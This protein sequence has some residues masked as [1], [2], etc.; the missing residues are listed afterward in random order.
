MAKGC[1]RPARLPW[2]FDDPPQSRIGMNEAIAAVDR[3]MHLHVRNLAQE[4]ITGL[5]RGHGPEEAR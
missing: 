2:R 1:G 5:G 3:E 4:H